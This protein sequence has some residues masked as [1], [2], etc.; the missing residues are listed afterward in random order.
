MKPK[1]DPRVEAYIVEAAEFAQPILRHLRRLVHEACPAVEETI[2]WNHA[3]FVLN[4]KILCMAG[5]FKAHCTFGFWHKDVQRLVERELGKSAEAG[6][7]L[8]R[9]TKI[10][11]L[12]DD[13]TMR[14][15]VTLAASLVDSGAPARPPS[16]PKPVLPVPADLAAALK[17]NAK[18]AKAFADFPPSHRRE[19]I[20]WITEA[21][22]EATRASR[23]ATAVA[24]IAAGKQRNWKYQN[25]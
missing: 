15:Y 17:K 13:A 1:T 2:K 20:V 7:M 22:R 21:K 24:W 9:I 23:L 10:A 3:S 19:Y 16:K 14:R 25:C 8:G 4:G 12:P 11:D 5:T 18:A 6:G